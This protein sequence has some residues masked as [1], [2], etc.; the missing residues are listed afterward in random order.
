M[1]SIAS[2]PA[3]SA[4]PFGISSSASAKAMIA[5]CSFRVRGRV[6]AKSCR[7][8]Y[9]RR[10]SA[11]YDLSVFYDDA[12]DMK[13]II[14]RALHFI[15]YMFCAAVYKWIRLWIHASFHIEHLIIAT[16]RSSTSAAF[17]CLR[18]NPSTFETTRA[19]WLL[20]FLYLSIITSLTAR[21][22]FFARNAYHDHQC[23]SVNKTFTPLQ[24]A[25]LLSPQRVCFLQA[26]LLR[27][28]RETWSES[29]FHC[30]F[31]ISIPV[32]STAILAFQRALAYLVSLALSMTTMDEFCIFYASSALVDDIDILLDVHFP[33]SLLTLRSQRTAWP[34]NQEQVCAFP[35]SAVFAIFSSTSSE[36]SIARSSRISRAFIEQGCNLL[37]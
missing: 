11:C 24:Q 19:L 28:V 4:M 9:F 18:S 15:S 14:K 2:R 37:W 35:V 22:P 12:Y 33:P 34:V 10:A 13:R 5:S 32:S 31:S 26:L 20:Q 17:Q 21:I 6:F 36:A 7:H 27:A 23:F 29:R 3:F 30:V 16:P 1:I 8:L 25:L